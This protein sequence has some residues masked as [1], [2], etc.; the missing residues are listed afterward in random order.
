MTQSRVFTNPDSLKT[1][2]GSRV[3]DWGYRG[4]ESG[5]S[6]G[7]E[8]DIDSTF[9]NTTENIDSID[10]ILGGESGSIRFCLKSQVFNSKNDSYLRYAQDERIDIVTKM[11]FII[12]KSLDRRMKDLKSENKGDRD[13]VTKWRKESRQKRDVW[14]QDYKSI[15]PITNNLDLWN[16]KHRDPLLLRTYIP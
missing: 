14:Y 8:S 5:I 4:W 11:K 3:V 1:M 12:T 16:L 15:K 13:S 6:R 7:L 9:I 2:G 10:G